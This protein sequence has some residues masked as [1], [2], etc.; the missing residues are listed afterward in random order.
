MNND[1]LVYYIHFPTICSITFNPAIKLLSAKIIYVAYIY[2]N[3]IYQPGN[4]LDLSLCNMFRD[5]A[6]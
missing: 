2:C 4:S 3:R 1:T 6:V 5:M